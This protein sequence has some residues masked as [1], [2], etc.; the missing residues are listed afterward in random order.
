MNYAKII[1]IATSMLV[2]SGCSSSNVKSY[3][4]DYATFAYLR[5]G[6]T[7]VMNIG[8]ITVPKGDTNSIMC[9]MVGNVYL[10]NKMTY[11]QY[12]REALHKVLVTADKFDDTGKAAHTL[13]IELTS[14]TF[15][16]VGGEWIIDGH[17]IIDSK[18]PKHVKTVT[19]FGT[20]F[21]AGSACH[22]AAGAFDEAVTDFV[23]ETLSQVK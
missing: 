16:S 10:P 22:N 8:T 20:A 21:D 7:P 19:K 4:A 12:L 13:S 3:K 6:A 17:L 5:T 9:R 11:S 23:K 18:S 15:S 14:V 2:L 1:L